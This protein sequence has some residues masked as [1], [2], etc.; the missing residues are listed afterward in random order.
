MQQCPFISTELEG[1]GGRWV[2]RS[3]WS[4]SLAKPVS[5]R[6]SEEL[7]VSLLMGSGLSFNLTL[8]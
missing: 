4:A 6:F 7:L 2:L 5:S 3:F 1:G 8:S